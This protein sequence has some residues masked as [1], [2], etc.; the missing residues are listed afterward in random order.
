LRSWLRKFALACGTISALFSEAAAQAVPGKAPVIALLDSADLPQWQTWTKDPGWQVIAVAAE[1]NATI[2]TRIQALE[3]AVLASIQNGA[4]DSSRVYL[5]GRGE[6]AATVFYTISRLPDL[7]AAGV[8]IGGSPEPAIDS[9]RFYT[10]NFG[11]MPVLW[12]GAGPDDR[13]TADRLRELGLALEFRPAESITAGSI[14]QWLAQHTR[15]EYPNAIDCETNSPA[16]GRCYWIQMTKFDAAER[17]DVLASTLVRPVL[18]AALDLG[19]FGFKKDAPGPGVLVSYLPPK[20]SGPLKMGDRIVSLDGREIPDPTRYID[21]MARIT[22]GREAVAMVQRG[23][24]HIRL[25]TR[26][27][28][29]KPAQAATAR[30]Q[31]KYLPEENDIQIVSRAVT[32]MRVEIPA[33]WLPAVL[34]WNGVP[35]EKIDAAGCRLLTI[36]KEIEKASRCP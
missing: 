1:P 29:P 11:N 16:F 4:A 3:K 19:G 5:A 20:Y 30:V 9:G 25:E 18:S 27:I 21:F 2:D 34:N 15:A 22:E 26:I 36:E 17:N 13:T 23:K 7:W 32:E 33:P 24:E 14:L 12:V 28:L 31:A 35:L 6:A 10:A 8:A